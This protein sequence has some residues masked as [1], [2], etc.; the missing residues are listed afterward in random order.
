MDGWMVENELS[1]RIG[2]HGSGWNR[3]AAYALGEYGTL[4]AHGVNDDFYATGT[5]R[6]LN[7][8]VSN[9]FFCDLK[10]NL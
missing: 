2:K 4:R 1:T 6:L 7:K 9:N 8:N 3:M 5:I 10:P